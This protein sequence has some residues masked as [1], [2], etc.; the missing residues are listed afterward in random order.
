MFARIQLEPTS[1]A[2]LASTLFFAVLLA[3]PA[4]GE[5]PGTA[6]APPPEKDKE[7]ADKAPIFYLR[8]GSK[9]AG[10]P[11]LETLQVTTSYGVL[12]IPRDQLVRIRF[13]RRV[14]AATRSRVEG[15]IEDLG[16]EDFDRREAASNSLA[17][18][19]PDAL[20]LL[21]KALKSSNE[22][23]KNRATR[24]IERIDSKGEGKTEKDEALPE[25]VG[26][27]DEVTTAKMTVRGTVSGEE[28]G[29]DSRYGELKIRIA[30]LAG[31][32]F[33]TSGASA[34]KVEVSA[35]NQAPQ[36]WVDTKLDVEKGQKLKIEATGQITVR[37]YGISSG[38][39]GN[40]DWGGNSFNNFPMLALVGKIG[41]RGQPFLIGPSFTGKANA[42]G[43]LHLAVVP[44]TPYAGGAT[45]S[46]QVKIQ[47]VGGD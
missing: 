4:S 17:E 5:E 31:A 7:A 13:A 42:S 21:R 36:N 45:G 35:Q 44:F 29:I 14:D 3:A 22:E 37:N 34:G 30:D 20:Q 40:R 47:T 41:R 10:M 23:V 38:P 6:P 19:G 24:L 27:E 18:V 26:A 32:I 39:E 1:P 28:I 33:R 2:R 8:D 46:Y 25:L 16:N 9:I 11:R 15:L 43:R 12:N